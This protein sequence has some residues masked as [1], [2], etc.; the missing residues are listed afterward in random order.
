MRGS[1]WKRP[2]TIG[3]AYLFAGGS[4]ALAVCA[5]FDASLPSPLRFWLAVIFGCF[6]VVLLV[7]PTRKPEAPPPPANLS[8]EP[9]PEEDSDDPPQIYPRAV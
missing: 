5:A 6:A 3:A 9:A 4:L 8:A 1:H 2:G 7:V